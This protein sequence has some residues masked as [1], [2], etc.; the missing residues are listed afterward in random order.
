MKVSHT[1]F[2]VRNEFSNYEI[3]SIHFL[4]KIQESGPH[5]ISLSF[6]QPVPKLRH[7]KVVY[8]ATFKAP[9]Q[10]KKAFYAMQG[11]KDF[12]FKPPVSIATCSFEYTF[13][14]CF[15]LLVAK[16]Q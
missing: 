8:R 10:F 1:T 7:Q 11:E 15:S 13:R 16:L 2:F 4:K 6:N 14:T 3:Q 9:N 5:T 12:F